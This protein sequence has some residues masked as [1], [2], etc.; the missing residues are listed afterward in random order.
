MVATIV[1]L[2]TSLSVCGFIMLSLFLDFLCYKQ[3]EDFNPLRNKGRKIQLAKKFLEGQGKWEPFC[4]ESLMSFGFKKRHSNV[5]V[6]TC[7]IF[8]RVYKIKDRRRKLGKWESFSCEKIR[9]LWN[10]S[11]F[12]LWIKNGINLKFNIL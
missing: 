11:I 1:V 4:C 3:R 6:V 9:L 10:N 2:L 12:N 7:S 5:V 8:A